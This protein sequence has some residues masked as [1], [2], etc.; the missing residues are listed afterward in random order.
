MLCALVA[1]ETSFDGTLVGTSY[2]Q[3]CNKL[4]VYFSDGALAKLYLGLAYYLPSWNENRAEFIYL[5]ELI[6]RSRCARR[7]LT[8]G[9]G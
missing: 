3:R 4:S 1:T 7:L 5:R 8:Y 9:Y 2:D 6:T